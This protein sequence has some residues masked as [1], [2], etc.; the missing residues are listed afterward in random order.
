MKINSFVTLIHVILFTMLLLGI[1]IAAAG[2]SSSNLEYLTYRFSQSQDNINLWTTVPSERVFKDDPLPEQT[3][4]LVQVYAAKNE[5]E[6]FQIVVKPDMSESVSVDITEFTADIKTEIHQVKYLN[7]TQATDALGKTGSYP[8]PLWPLEKGKSISLTANENTSF[9]ITVHVPESAPSGDYTAD[10]KINSSAGRVFIPVSLHVFDFTIPRDIHTKSQMN[11]SHNTILSKYGVSGYANEYWMYVDM[12]KQFFIDHRLT[13]KSV[14]WSGGVTG[15]GAGPYI[16]YDCAGT[17]TDKDGIWGFEE[18]AARYLDGTGTMNGNFGSDFNNG[19]GFPSFMAATFQNNDASDDQRPDEFCGETRTASD[20]YT[21]NNPNSNYNR[22]WF[23]YIAG[24]EDYLR[25]ANYLDKAYYY[26]ANEPQNQEDY[27]AVA[28]Y[29]QELKQAAPNLKLMVSEEAKPEIFDHPLYTE[30]KIDIWL[31]V[32]NNYDPKTAHARAAF[33]EETWIYWL[34]GT[35][36]PYFNPITLDHPGIESKFTGWFLWKYRIRGIA[37][38]S[39][40]NWSKNPWTDPINDGHN[41]DLFMIYPPS[42]T[43][44]TIEYGSN[45]HR[46]VTSIRFELMRDSLEDYEYLYVLNNGE[47]PEVNVENQADILTDKIITGTAA[48]TRDS[49]FMYN[50]RRLIGMK[51]GREILEIPDIQPPSIHPRTEGPPGNYY[52]NFQAPYESFNTNPWGSP[53]MGDE[54]MSGVPYRILN[55]NG[56]SYFAVGAEAYDEDR[57]FGWFGNIINQPGERRDPWGNETDERK[58]TY[59]YDDYGRINTFEFALPSGQYSV[60]LCVGT[61]QEPIR[62]QQCHHRRYSLYFG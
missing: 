4:S 16:D 38:Y 61:P 36:P 10:F 62:S 19:T 26:I 31:P 15:T 6:P 42:E 48:Y 30:A 46:F 29:S 35:R 28:W 27:D 45:N 41:G 60:F 59:I 20:W 7:I 49:E 56:K 33:D 23:S 44:D 1:N 5:F 55:Y 14:L 18:P 54:T 22:K 32:M 43:N 37:Y 40:N 8:D 12:I 17:L 51:N 58:R 53:V 25:A 24:L 50:L 2:E 9:W 13:P 3:G 57:G 11:F 47:N 39:L 52:I 34:H 21:A